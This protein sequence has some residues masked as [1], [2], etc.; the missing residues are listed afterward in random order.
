[1]PFGKP[2]ISVKE[3]YDSSAKCAELMANEN[4][5]INNFTMSK[6]MDKVRHFH[7]TNLIILNE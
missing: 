7:Q 5:N 2:S 1:M 6:L 3:I 4:L